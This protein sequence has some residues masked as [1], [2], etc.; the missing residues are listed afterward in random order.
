[1]SRKNSAQRSTEYKH[2][3]TLTFKGLTYRYDK[4]YGEWH[5]V[6]KKEGPLS[7]PRTIFGNHDRWGAGSL[8]VGSDT[9]LAALE[10]WLASLIDLRSREAAEAAQHAK[11]LRDEVR[12]LKARTWKSKG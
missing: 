5:L 2:R 11:D 10:A 9:P 3:E 1:M 7:L 6:E 8:A 12:R 4:S